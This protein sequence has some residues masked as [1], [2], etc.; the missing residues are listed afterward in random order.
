[1]NQHRTGIVSRFLL[2]NTLKSAYGLKSF[3]YNEDYVVSNNNNNYNVTG[4]YWD[5]KWFSRHCTSVVCHCF[6][7]V[8]VSYHSQIAHNTVCWDLICWSSWPR[9]GYARFWTALV[10][11]SWYLPPSISWGG[12]P[13]SQ[14]LRP[15]TISLSM[16]SYKPSATDR[17][18]STNLFTSLSLSIDRWTKLILT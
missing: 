13:L 3:M 9:G 4:N 17:L 16:I 18:V 10:R 1:V 6:L 8:R 14:H 15:H 11:L 7:M 5:E 12:S 2:R